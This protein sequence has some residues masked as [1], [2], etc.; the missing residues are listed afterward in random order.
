M[1]GGGVGEGDIALDEPNHICRQCKLR[2]YCGAD[3][4][5]VDID[6]QT[7]NLDVNRLAEKLVQAEEDGRLPKVLVPVHL[8]GQPCDMGG[9]ARWPN[10]T[11]LRSSKMRRMRLALEIPGAHRLPQYSDIT[12]FSFHPVKII[13]TAEGGM[14]LTNNGNL[15]S[16]CGVAQPWHNPRP[17][18]R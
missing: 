1:P 13:T 2:S 10:D 5:F 15:P 14:A 8:S 3:V 12:V 4:D 17:C 11:A 6:P 9:I 7:Y 16:A 18:T